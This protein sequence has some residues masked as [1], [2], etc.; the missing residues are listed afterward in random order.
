M[1]CYINGENPLIEAKILE[2]FRKFCYK[3]DPLPLLKGRTIK[4]TNSKINTF[5]EQ[6]LRGNLCFYDENV[7]GFAVFGDGQEWLDE[8]VEEFSNKRVSVLIM[9]ATHNESLSQAKLSLKILQES[10]KIL[11]ETYGYNVVAWNQNRGNKRKPFE[12]ILS[13]LGAEKIKTCYYV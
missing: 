10:F 1:H 5:F 9:G 4:E 6:K 12:R 3:S 2:C 13:T 11:K 7:K 8:K